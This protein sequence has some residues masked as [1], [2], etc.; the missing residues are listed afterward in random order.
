MRASECGP[1][2]A[3]VAG[4]CTADLSG[5]VEAGAPPPGDTGPAPIDED[6]QVDVDTGPGDFDAGPDFDSGPDIDSGPAPVDSGPAPVDSGPA[7]V[8]SGPA[9]DAG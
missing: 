8:D 5:L 1:G 6:A 3:C 4:M 7:P 9:V 2:L